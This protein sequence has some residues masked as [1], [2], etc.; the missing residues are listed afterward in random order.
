MHAAQRITCMHSGVQQRMRA[1]AGMQGTALGGCRNDR[2]WLTSDALSHLP[3]M[4]SGA[5]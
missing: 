2:H 4:T 3:M 5:M 1:L